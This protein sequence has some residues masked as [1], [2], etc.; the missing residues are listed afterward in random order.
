MLPQPNGRPLLVRGRYGGQQ[1]QCLNLTFSDRSIVAE[2]WPES[3][4]HCVR[5]FAVKSLDTG[6]IAPAY[7][8]TIRESQMTDAVA[9]DIGYSLESSR[10][11]IVSTEGNRLF[12]SGRFTEAIE[13]ARQHHTEFRKGTDIPYMAHLL[14]VAALVMGEAGGRVLVTED[15]VL[16]ALLHDVVEDHGGMTRLHEVEQRF[17][18]NVARMVEGLSDSFAENQQPKDEWKKRKSEYIE[19]LRHEPDDVLLISSADKLYNAKAILDDFKDIGEAIWKRFNRGGDQQL[20]YFD[21]LVAVY[22]LRPRNR[23]VNELERV[24]GE[25]AALTPKVSSEE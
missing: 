11:Q 21:E 24:V 16:A 22:L 25:L 6:L 5:R 1:W 13:Y 4:P 18:A 3:R 10:R 23:I 14:G 20:W 2:A 7:H 9:V 12:L 15:M 17:G 19:R 8:S